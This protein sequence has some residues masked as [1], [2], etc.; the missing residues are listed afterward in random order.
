MSR[1]VG[2][3]H[4]EGDIYSGPQRVS[5]SFLGESGEKEEYI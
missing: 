1:L 2:K 4:R 3:I 5:R